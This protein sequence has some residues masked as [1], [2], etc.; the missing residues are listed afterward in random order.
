MTLETNLEA[1]GLSGLRKSFGQWLAS[2]GIG[3][4]AI[5]FAKRTSV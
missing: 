3:R 1:A 2:N 5:V 4:E